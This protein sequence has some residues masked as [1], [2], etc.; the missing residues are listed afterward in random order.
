MQAPQHHPLGAWSAEMNRAAALPEHSPEQDRAMF[1]AAHAAR[2]A[3]ASARRAGD[4]ETGRI[5]AH[6]LSLFSEAVKVPRP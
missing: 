5:A 4:A 2:R 1:R 6:F 3:L